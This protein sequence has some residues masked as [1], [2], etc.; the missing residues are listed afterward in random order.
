MSWQ[1]TAHERLSDYKE[2]AVKKMTA[3][4][5]G[6]GHSGVVVAKKENAEEDG[7]VESLLLKNMAPAPSDDD[8][9]KD[10]NI[11]NSC[12]RVIRGESCKKFGLCWLL[13]LFS[14]FL[15][16]TV[17]LFWEDMHANPNK[18]AVG[19]P[20]V[21]D[22]ADENLAEEAE[23]FGTTIT[24]LAGELKDEALEAEVAVSY[25]HLTLPTILLV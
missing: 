24:E 17:L 20:L 9:E 10:A 22:A 23:E 11:V 5:I 21:S 16:G 18:D 15:I 7:N 2:N 4:T 1:T 6:S 25:T 19:R 13:L 8:D 12:C 14:F 3:S